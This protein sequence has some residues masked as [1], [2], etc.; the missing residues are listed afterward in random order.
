MI[1]MNRRDEMCLRCAT[2]QQACRDGKDPLLDFS[3]LTVLRN[4]AGDDAMRVYQSAEQTAFEAYWRGIN[5][6]EAALIVVEQFQFM[7]NIAIKATGRK[8][9]PLAETGMYPPHLATTT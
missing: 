3:S 4:A 7:Q 2:I 5:D 9:V 8:L 6:R 1:K